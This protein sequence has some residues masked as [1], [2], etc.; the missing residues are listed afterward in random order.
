[1]TGVDSWGASLPYIYIGIAV[2]VLLLL[3]LAWL[4]FRHQADAPPPRTQLKFGWFRWLWA[5]VP[6]A[7]IGWWINTAEKAR[8]EQELSQR[9]AQALEAAG[10]NWAKVT[11]NG[12]DGIISGTARTAEDDKAA[13]AIVAQLPGVRSLA[14]RTDVLPL[15]KP[16]S[17]RAKRYEGKIK[18]TGHVPSEQH[19]KSVLSQVQAMFPN[20]AMTDTMIIA[21]GEPDLDVW[22]AGVSFGLHQLAKLKSGNVSLTDTALSLTGT[23]ATPDQYEALKAALSQLPKGISLKASSIKPPVV[24]PY[25]FSAAEIAGQLVLSGFVPDE[26]MRQKVVAEVQAKFPE[27]TVVNNLKIAAGAPK[28]F[29]AGVIAGID[30]LKELDKGKLEMNGKKITISG[31]AAHQPA[32]QQTVAQL[33]TALQNGFT[34][35]NKI[36]WKVLDPYTWS[37]ERRENELVFSGH[38]PN[39]AVRQAIFTAASKAFPGL[40]QRDDMTLASGAIK[41]NVWQGAVL[42]ALNQLVDLH[43]GRVA[44]RNKVMSIEG[45][46][47]D[48]AAYVA[49]QARLNQGGPRGF[50]W[51]NVKLVEPPKPQP[52]PAP[53]QAPAEAEDGAEPVAEEQSGSA[54]SVGEGAPH[55][56]EGAEGGDG[57]EKSGAA[58][59]EAQ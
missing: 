51:G 41:P 13:R 10:Q 33:K 46:P 25:T 7:A 5:L 26:T 11:F 52:I 22:N 49:L 54:E 3:C 38:V 28:S 15:A 19:R 53:E 59:I 43:Q 8:I 29:A 37:A 23:A 45:H 24:R 58:P 55:G 2:A 57:E 6:L 9:A 32:A 48:Y 16:Y 47:K 50:S 35:I 21:A 44:L 18:L 30:S 20:H 14:A 56:E 27:F 12:R 1:M 34:L 39:Q 17:W 4:F 42:F 31:Q 36:S 40:K